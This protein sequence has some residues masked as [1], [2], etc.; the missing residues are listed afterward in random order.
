MK[1]NA[2]RVTRYSSAAQ[3]LTHVQPLLERRESFNTLILGICDTLVHTPE[4]YP[5]YWLW[6]VDNEQDVNTVAILTSPHDL[7]VYAEGLDQT[8]VS[9]LAQ[10]LHEQKMVLPGVV[11]AAE[12][13][14]G[15]AEAWSNLT[16]AAT[17]LRRHSR[18]YEVRQVLFPLDVQGRC[19]Q[20]GAE[21]RTL[22]SSWVYDFHHGKLPPDRAEQIADVH[23]T[24]RRMYLWEAAG[25]PV[26]M[27]VGPTRQSQHGGL[28]NFVY[29]P[30]EQR[31]RGYASAV[32]A[33]LSQYILDSGKEFCALF[34]NLANPVSNSIYQKIGYVPCGDFDE[35]NFA[36]HRPLE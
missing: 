4:Q 23:I 18:V 9:Q 26:S 33:T 27:A 31:R 20:A 16:G 2:M 6:T 29:T 36:V 12:V 30:P 28:I 7:I 5:N 25:T 8:A 32:V 35:M 3:F 13:V 22:V 34:T 11:G 14:H 19:I 21:H 17:S 15:F 10:H 24:N 1:A